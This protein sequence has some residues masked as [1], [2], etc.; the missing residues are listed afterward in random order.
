VLIVRGPDGRELL[1]ET[2]RARGATVDYLSV[3]ERNTAAVSDSALTE[4]TNLLKHGKISWVVVMS[5]QTLSALL[6]ILPS[7]LHIKL[8]DVWLV[9]PANRVIQ[10]ALK[11]LPG[12]RAIL[13][14]TPQPA[15]IVDAIVQC[16]EDRT[17]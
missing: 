6:E 12:V 4:V 1:A 5:I 7:E 2:L 13:A 11:L 16:R 8:L 17:D 10:T 3:Y 14:A 9:T 15:G